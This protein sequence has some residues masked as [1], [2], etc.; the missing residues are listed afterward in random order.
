MTVVKDVDIDMVSAINAR[1]SLVTGTDLFAG[2]L[3]P[4][5]GGV[6]QVAVGVKMI[7]APASTRYANG[8]TAAGELHR[9]VAFVVTARGSARDPKSARD[10][11]KL[12]IEAMHHDPPTGYLDVRMGGAP[13][14]VPSTDGPLDIPYSTVEG[15]ADYEE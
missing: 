12:V 13:F 3:P 11:V 7:G 2:D 8:G 14:D 10:K 9:D 1:T 4:A 6:S 15:F 5:G